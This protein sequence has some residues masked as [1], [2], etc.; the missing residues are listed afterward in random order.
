[1]R[2]ANALKNAAPTC[3]KARQTTIP[4]GEG[5]R[6]IADRYC[7]ALQECTGTRRGRRSAK[8]EQNW[9]AIGYFPTVQAVIPYL[10]EYRLRTSGVQSLGEALAE[11]KRIRRDLEFPEVQQ[12]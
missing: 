8:R 7:W 11:C 3:A 9:R 2:S 1:M 5:F 12:G 4:L 10:V 6:L